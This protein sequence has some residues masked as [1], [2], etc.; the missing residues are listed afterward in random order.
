M[1][2]TAEH[3][4]LSEA[5]LGY[6]NEIF[7]SDETFSGNPKG[8]SVNASREWCQRQTP[9]TA[10]G[11][12]TSSRFPSEE[13]HHATESRAAI[14]EMQENNNKQDGKSKTVIDVD[15]EKNDI[16]FSVVV[17]EDCGPDNEEE[18]VP[19][20]GWGYIVIIGAFILS[21]SENS[22]VTRGS[23]AKTTHS[24]KTCPSVLVSLITRFF[25]VLY[26]TH[27]SNIY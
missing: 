20:G 8:D 14:E 22:S 16:A 24:T 26:I 25:S 12:L 17:V 21:A 6:L 2:P 9:G 13:T 19:D 4:S 7:E 5:K 23:S 1:S 11:T 10:F 27:A 18:E 15:C 3:L